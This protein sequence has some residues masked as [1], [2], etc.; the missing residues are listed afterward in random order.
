MSFNFK[1]VFS[2]WNFVVKKLPMKK[3]E[4]VEQE[5]RLKPYSITELAE[6]YEC[7]LKT[8]KTWLRYF[9]KEL[10]PR[11]GHY[12]TPKQ[13]KIIFEELGVP[14]EKMIRQEEK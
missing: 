9:E 7:S 14:R 8:L 2:W 4:T 6:L 11:M 10:G 12:Y 13:I 3:K 1:G 5:I